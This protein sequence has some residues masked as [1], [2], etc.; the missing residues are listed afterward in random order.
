MSTF[1]CIIH[2]R[3]STCHSRC[4][5]RSL[6]WMRSNPMRYAG[7]ETVLRWI[8]VATGSPSGC[9]FREELGNRVRT[10]GLAANGITNWYC[11]RPPRWKRDAFY[12]ADQNRQR[13]NRI[14]AQ[15]AQRC[16]VAGWARETNALGIQLSRNGRR[17]RS[18]PAKRYPAP[19]IL[20]PDAGNG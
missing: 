1:R 8:A 14:M 17:T 15:V 19:R 6:G 5:L 3:G 12:R 13:E 20:F 9:N 16:G 18:S 4:Q 10:D 7:E 2:I 11:C